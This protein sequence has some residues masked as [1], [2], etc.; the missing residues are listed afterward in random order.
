M[1]DMISRPTD[2]ETSA[3]AEREITESDERAR[4]C[5]VALALVKK[6]P[7]LTANE[8][9]AQIG[10]SDG[11]VRKRLRDLER[12]GLVRKGLVRI[13]TVT[14]KANHTWWLA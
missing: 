9:E 1:W 2:P 8:L 11:R 5:A 10:V 4:A 6:H 13:S 12:A 14:G 3:R 7:G